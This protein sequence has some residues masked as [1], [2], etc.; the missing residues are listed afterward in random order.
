MKF[1]KS[2]VLLSKIEI[3]IMQGKVLYDI[4]LCFKFPISDPTLT[5]YERGK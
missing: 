2:C 4:D 1:K 5:A 3:E